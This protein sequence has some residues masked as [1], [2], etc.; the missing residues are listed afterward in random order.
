MGGIT[1]EL[2][3]A[4][5]QLRGSPWFAATAILMLALGIS[6][7]GTALSWIDGTM[8]RPVPGARET[9]QLTCKLVMPRTS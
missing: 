3:F 9:G 1:R 4:L 5:R 8:L 2:R 7:T 6:A